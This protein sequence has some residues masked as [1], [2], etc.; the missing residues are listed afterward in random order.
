MVRIV[1]LT[2]DPEKASAFEGLFQERMMLIRHFPGCSHLALLKSH[3]PGGVFMTYSIWEDQ[4]ALDAYRHS[5][6]FAEIWATIKPWFTG[7]PEAWSLDDIT[8]AP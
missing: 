3:M 7:K 8:P 4:Q 5:G 1:K 2:I 6:M